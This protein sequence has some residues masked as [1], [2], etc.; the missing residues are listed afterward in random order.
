MLKIWNFVYICNYAMTS[1]F[2]SFKFLSHLILKILTFK[3]GYY[4][5]KPKTKPVRKHEV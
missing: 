2:Q 4:A 1:S 3:W 5:S